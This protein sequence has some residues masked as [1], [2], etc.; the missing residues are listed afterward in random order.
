MTA[1]SARTERS[2]ADFY[3][4]YEVNKSGDD[5]LQF[6]EQRRYEEDSR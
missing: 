6:L 5:V 2:K 1:R 3:S 4:T